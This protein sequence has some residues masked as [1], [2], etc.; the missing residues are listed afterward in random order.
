MSRPDFSYL[1]WK[2]AGLVGAALA[3]AAACGDT[4]DSDPDATVDEPDGAVADPPDG[5]VNDTPD[6]AVEGD[7]DAAPDALA[8]AAPD[9]LVDAAPDA[10]VDAAP[11]AL[12][13]AAPD[14]APDARPDAAV[15]AGVDA[16][17]PT[18]ADLTAVVA[19]SN[20]SGSV[21]RLTTSRPTDFAL[22]LT[23]GHCI[24]GGFLE[25]GEVVGNRRLRNNRQ[26]SVLEP[27]ALRPEPA[28]SRPPGGGVRV[29]V[30]ANELIY[31]TM[32]STDMALYRLTITYEALERDHDVHAMTIRDR[33]PEAGTAILIPSGYWHTLFS[34]SIDRFVHGLREGEW[35][36]DDSIRYSTD[37]CATIGGTSGSPIVAAAT[38]EVVGV[39]NTANENGAA[40]SINNPCEV[41]AAG[42]MTSVPDAR[43]GQQVY[44]IYDCL[45]ATN[46]LD[47][48]LPGCLLPAPTTN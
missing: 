42:N 45:T 43:Y 39:N 13:D 48:D 1:A 22:V 7:P 10:L 29:G 19:L 17:M 4:P 18:P 47:F 37:G 15:D 20:C 32:T 26:M 35:T 36:F 38:H 14:A 24:G 33:H 6:G 3:L 8:D 16:G 2:R 30:Q 27:G 34:C 5:A 44:L 11:D 21:V 23:N 46:E 28:P 25:P 12:V 31:A 40:C 9:A 41:D